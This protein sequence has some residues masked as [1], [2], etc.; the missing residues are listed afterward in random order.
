MTKSR[1][2]AAYAFAI[3]AFV[4]LTSRYAYLQMF[5]HDILLLRSINNYSSSVDTSPVRGSIL[6][7]NG[8]TLG[9]NRVSYVVAI[10]PKDA[11]NI[12]DIFIRLNK[13]INIS[14]FDKK[15]Y[16]RQARKSKKYD[17][18]TIKDDLSNTEVA[19][20][21]A[22]A[23]LFP[24]LSV[25]AHSKR[26]YPYADLYAHSI[27]YVGRVSYND[28][29]KME[30]NGTT[31]DYMTD[32]YIGKNGLELQYE[33]FLRGTLGK[34]VIQTDAFG[35][36]TGLISNISAIDGNTIELTIDNKL[37]QRASTLLGDRKGA[38]VV[39]DVKTGG[40]L[41][42]VSK[43]SFDP[44]WFIDGITPDDWDEL[45]QDPSKP[46]LN[47]ATQGTYPPGSTFK[48]FMA[49]AALYLGIRTPQWQ[50]KETGLFSLP[51]TT[52]VFRGLV[53]GGYGMIDMKKAI[54]YS[55]DTYFYKLGAD[56]GID[57]I[58]KVMSLFGFGQKTG[59]DLPQEYVGL[60]PSRE[61]KAKRFKNDSYQKNW[62][63]A[64][65]V[66]IGIGQ[67]FNHYTPLQM[68]HAVSIIANDGKSITPHF[69]SAIL[70]NEGVIESYQIESSMLPIPKK[71]F[72]IIKDAMQSVVTKGTLHNVMRGISYTMGAK[73]GTAQVVALN[74]DN[75]KQ[76]FAG[77][78]YKDHAWVIAFAPV[79]KPQ[80]AIA[81][82]VENGGF[83][84]SA[85]AP[86]VRGI[87]DYYFHGESDIVISRKKN[88]S[89]LVV[90]PVKSIDGD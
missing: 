8:I 75:R 33:S 89:G 49:I 2:I 18:V 43:P 16:Y 22:N 66:N 5:N 45:N 62:L 38:I 68:A 65:S 88:S 19:Q 25:F 31:N 42:F 9:V 20:L 57:N 78:K 74:K 1:I 56:M 84:A 21:T 3:L 85:A 14:E 47:R 53:L 32:D 70:G 30:K 39:L 67:G 7:K 40:V 51:G 61:W 13:F 35:N 87:M 24:E 37:Q 81:T 55:S 82:I 44:N 83:G 52:H 23:Y 63:A 17:W 12:E 15:K 54:T 77:D 76:K 27:G 60:L 34:K 59:I 29:Q 71:D 90:N 69:L 50:M 11:K 64:D 10:L 79:D 86:I 26:Y 41:A 80:I 6:D 73:T 58:D 4:I 28:Q 48:P 36:E 46:L 72:E